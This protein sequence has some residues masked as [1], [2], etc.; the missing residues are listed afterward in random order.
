MTT[1]NTTADPIG[2]LWVGLAF[3]AFL[4]GPGTVFVIAGE[5]QT[6]AIASTSPLGI[7]MMV[8][9]GLY[10]RLKKAVFG[11]ESVCSTK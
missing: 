2:Q 4:F 5:Y 10:G 6:A 3:L 1:E 11:G 9:S 8:E 7:V